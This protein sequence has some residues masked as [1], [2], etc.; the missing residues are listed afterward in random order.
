MDS[1]DYFESFFITLCQL[2]Q[3]GFFCDIKL[4][5][6]DA[7]FSAHRIVLMAGSAYFH[8]MFAS[9]MAEHRKEIVTIG[10]VTPKIFQALLDFIYTGMCIMCSCYIDKG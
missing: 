4:Q 8:A 2:R 10:G 9:D 6:E 3:E 5:V 1:N 7:T